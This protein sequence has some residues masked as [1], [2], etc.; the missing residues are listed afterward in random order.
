MD[1]DT[2]LASSP[3]GLAVVHRLLLVFKHL[4]VGLVSI[5][6]NIDH[7]DFIESYLGW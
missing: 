3:L 6:R 1:S 4:S 5:W 2:V 7:Q